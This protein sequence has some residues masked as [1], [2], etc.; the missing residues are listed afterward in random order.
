M[1][2]IPED[3][4]VDETNKELKEAERELL[5]LKEITE[6]LHSLVGSGGEMLKVCEKS[7]RNG[8]IKI[9][10]STE[11]LKHACET[12]SLRLGLVLIP[13]AIGA[14]TGGP[15]GA[16]ISLKAATILGGMFAGGAAGAAGGLYLR[17][18]L[19]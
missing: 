16:L 10:T 7:S 18:K 4:S 8:L 5:A 17:S 1:I 9:V 12:S 3:Y 6:I 11:I 19:S 13:V 15:I 2:E 14:S